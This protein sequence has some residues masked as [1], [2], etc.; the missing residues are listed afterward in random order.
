M[1]SEIPL[2]QNCVWTIDQLRDEIEGL[3]TIVPLLDGRNVSYVFLDNGASTPSFRH[4]NDV[5]REFMPFYSGVH[6][7]SGFKSLLATKI[8]DEAHDLA[9]EFVGADP[10]RNVTIFGKN[11]TEVVNKLAN[12]CDWR[13]DD[14]VITTMMEHH[15]NDLPWRKHAKV[16]HVPVNDTGY[17]DIDALKAAFHQYRGR[18]RFFAVTGA[19]NITGI[20]NPIHDFAKLAHENGALIFVDAAQLAPHRA[21]D[22]LPN[23]DPGHI[24]FIAY[25]AHKMYAPFGIGVM[26]GDREWFTQGEPDM[27]GGGVVEVV[28]EEY[29][30]WSLPPAKEEAGSP[31]VPGAVALATAIHILTSAGMDEIADHE[32]DLVSYAIEK[33]SRI[34]GMILYGPTAKNELANKVG[35]ISFNIEGVSH[36]LVS[37]ILSV[38]GGIGVRNG[39]FCAHPYVKRLLKY[40]E[41]EAK[42]VT[43]E[44]LAGDRR[45]LPGMV[46]ASFGCYN[47]FEDVDRLVSVLTM[48][49]TGSQKGEY[50]MDVASGS[51]WPK[52]FQYNFAPYFPHF[53]LRKESSTTGYGEAS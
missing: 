29:V 51:C 20:V 44:I 32:H 43:A 21:I 25:S 18:V 10:A 34:P 17:L 12:R 4:V 9:G 31:N 16:V 38:E 1:N 50:E 13:P 28:E 11:T 37:A 27:V 42:A 3:Q 8:Y 15:S 47:N 6:R 39:C 48:I 40:D 35:V 24:D 26:V 46:R 52:N 23:D 49:A 19:S 33:M 36:A 2:L 5:V 14:V 53:S 30:A 7:G 22:V 45:R 41:Q